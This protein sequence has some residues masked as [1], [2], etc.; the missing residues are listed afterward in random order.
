MLTLRILSINA[1]IKK[2]GSNHFFF[3]KKSTEFDFA[4][5]RKLTVNAINFVQLES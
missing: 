3:F 2:S 4:C 1:D 5:K